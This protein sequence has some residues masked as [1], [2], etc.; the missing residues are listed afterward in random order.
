MAGKKKMT[1]AKILLLCAAAAMALAACNKDSGS[2]PAAQA[3]QQHVQPRAPVAPRPGATAA[4]QTLGMVQA[5]GQ[6]KST[7]P[8]EL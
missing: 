7:V 5:A 6:G 3:V 2:T 1:S 8:L 4:E